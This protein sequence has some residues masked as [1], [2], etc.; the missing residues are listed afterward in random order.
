MAE[1][2]SHTTEKLR[3]HGRKRKRATTDRLDGSPSK[4]SKIASELPR[5]SPAAGGDIDE[6]IGQMDPGLLADHVAKKIK[7]SFRELSSIELE[8]M[9][10]SQK[11]FYDTSEF[12]MAR[13]LDNLPA[14]LEHFSSGNESLATSDESTGS[15]HTLVVAASG[16]RAADVTRLDLYPVSCGYMLISLQGLYE[17]INHKIVQ[18]RSCLQNTLSFRKQLSIA[19]VPGISSTPPSLLI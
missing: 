4:A 6:S 2:A 13:R 5:T 17:G 18:W 7:R 19:S 12:D 8:D 3:R 10:L 15:P 16:L 1:G 11:V 14:F 9:Y